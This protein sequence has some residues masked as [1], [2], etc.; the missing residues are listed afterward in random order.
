MSCSV[1]W[2]LRS[3]GQWALRCQSAHS[4]QQALQ[5]AEC[6]SSSH[7]PLIRPTWQAA[8]RCSRAGSSSGSLRAKVAPSQ[9]AYSIALSHGPDHDN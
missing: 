9:P 4:S 8:S 5:R 3:A 2:H 7:T 6:S 1:P